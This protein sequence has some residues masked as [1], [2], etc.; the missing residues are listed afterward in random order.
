[1]YLLCTRCV[2]QF[3]QRPGK[4]RDLVYY[5]LLNAF[6]KELLTFR[7]KFGCSEIK[8]KPRGRSQSRDVNLRRSYICVSIGICDSV[9]K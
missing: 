7:Q 1:M 2:I 4:R 5:N 8:R 3:C 6:S 9:E